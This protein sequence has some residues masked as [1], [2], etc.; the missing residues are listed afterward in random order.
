MP[1]AAVDKAPDSQ[2][3]EASSKL[4]ERKSFIIVI[5]LKCNYTLKIQGGS[6]N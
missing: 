2:W 3:V 6:Q 4:Q 5:L 1:R